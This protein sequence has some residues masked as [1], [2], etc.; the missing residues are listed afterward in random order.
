M[1]DK[2]SRVRHLPEQ[3]LRQYGYVQTIPRPPTYIGRLAARDV[4]MTFMEF[5]LYVLSQQHRGDLILDGESWAHSRGYMRWFI[6]V[7]HPIANPPATIP[8]YTVDAHPRPVPPYEE[9]IVEQQ[10][11]KHPPEPYQI[12][13]NIRAKV[14]SAMGHHV[15]FGNPEVLRMM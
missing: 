4:A 5:S 9:V 13:N 12:I 1:A 6:R 14:N 10:W 15:V 11:T 7:S 3:V 2:D 8:D